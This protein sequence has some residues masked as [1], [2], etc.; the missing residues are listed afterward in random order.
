MQA[1][2]ERFMRLALVLGARHQGRT[3]PNPAVGAVVVAGSEREPVIVAQGIT[4][5]G[6]RPHAERVAL[7]AAG[8]A[9]RGATLYVSL[10]PCSHHGRS[11]PCVDAILASGVG[12]VVVG[13]ADPS[14]DAGG[15]AERHR[16]AGVDVEMEERF[17]A[18]A[19]IEGWLTWTRLGRP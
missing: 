17:E 11:P 13:T 12:R 14:Q 18:R 15:G 6:G 10:E 19:L 3:R 8:V 4:Q 5:P 7:A 16:A 1:H 2:D 9:A